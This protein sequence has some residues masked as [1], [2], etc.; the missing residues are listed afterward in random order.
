MTLVSVASLGT[1]SAIMLAE[2]HPV[3]SPLGA[4]Y[5]IDETRPFVPIELA[6]GEEATI[7]LVGRIRD[8]DAVRDY[9]MPGTGV[10]FETA[11][12]TIRWLL[13]STEVEMPLRQVLQVDAPAQGQCP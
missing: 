1:E 5:A 11:R 12:L 6:A 13:M 10:R 8:C 3:L 7:Q 9:W 2:L 4:M